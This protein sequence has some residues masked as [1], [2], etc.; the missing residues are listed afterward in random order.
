MGALPLKKPARHRQ[1]RTSDRRTR[2]EVEARPCSPE[3]PRDSGN[4]RLVR[5]PEKTSVSERDLIV[6][7]MF[8]E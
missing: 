4:I 6:N 2:V 7:S 8:H 3:Q 1:E 5:N